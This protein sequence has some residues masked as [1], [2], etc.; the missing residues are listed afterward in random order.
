MLQSLTIKNLALIDSLEMEFTDGLNILTGETGAGKSVL[1]GSV[2]LALGEKADSSVIRDGAKEALIEMVFHVEEE[3][4]LQAIREMDL[5]V[6]E[7]G[8]LIL[9]R[10]ILPNRSV[11][12]VSGES[13]TLKQ[14][15]QLASLLINIHG[16]ND[17]L[18]LLS[19]SAQNA[20]VDA[21]AGEDATREKAAVADAFRAMSDI[22][23]ELDSMR[24]DAREREREAD[25]IRYEIAEIEEA[26]LKE[27]EDEELEQAFRR[28]ANALKITETLGRASSL[29]REDADGALA[30]LEQSIRLLSPLTQADAR[31][32][33]FASGLTDAESILRDTVHEMEAY[34]EDSVFDEETLA[35][36]E[37]RL[38]LINR[39][40]EKY[41]SAHDGIAGILSYRDARE[42]ELSRLEDYEAYCEGRRKEMEAFHRKAQEAADRLSAL[43]KKAAA[44]L[45]GRLKDALKDLNFAEAKVT[46]E[47]SSDPDALTAAGC[48]T[49]TFLISTN[50]GEPLRPLSKIVSGGELSR[51]MLGLKTVLSDENES[52]AM[53]FDEIDAGISGKTA[54]KVSSKLGELA[55]NRQVICITHLPQIAAMADTHYLIYK[56]LSGERAVTRIR[57][58]TET[59]TTEEI[60]RLISTDD[61][62]DTAKKSAGEMRAEAL[63]EKKKWT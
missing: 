45:S 12:K 26:A 5:S 54:W 28:G 57:T 63:S 59:E 33:E 2:N 10:R 62:S 42:T 1:I 7:D 3:A 13:V 21:V 37:K 11:A 9:Q 34:L 29:L 20:L 16:Q 17:Q 19:A 18:S 50:P 44:Q 30:G 23:R 46:I 6:E 53:I 36:Q 41:D 14:L 58:L 43:R 15:R 52:M 61:I 25:L 22:R 55:A 40:K 48:D 51:I 60:A 8:C 35:Q 24:L 31:I 4:V 49:V 47:V 56:D 39:L 32:G 27:G 38:N